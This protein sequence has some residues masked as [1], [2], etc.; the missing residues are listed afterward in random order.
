MASRSRVAE[1]SKSEQLLRGVPEKGLQSVVLFKTVP[2]SGGPCGRRTNDR[3]AGWRFDNNGHRWVVQRG[4]RSCQCF[5]QRLS[6]MHDRQ[7]K[8]QEQARYF[9]AVAHRVDIGLI[10]LQESVGNDTALAGD[11]GRL[12]ESGSRAQADGGENLVSDELLS[13]GQFKSES[14]IVAVVFPDSF[15]RSAEVKLDALFLQASGKCITGGFR[16]QA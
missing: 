6:L 15:D 4:G 2:V 5:R 11:A 13:V 3:R 12:G 14:T 9:S 8:G 1:Q 16:Q 7:Y 10:G